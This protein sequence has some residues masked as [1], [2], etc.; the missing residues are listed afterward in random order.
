MFLGSLF[1]PSYR[2][3][4]SLHGPALPLGHAG[5]GKA[6][7]PTFPQRLPNSQNLRSAVGEGHN[8]D[9]IAHLGIPDGPCTLGGDFPPDNL[10]RILPD[11]ILFYGHPE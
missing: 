1:F 7:L 10:G 4:D 9:I 5:R 2:G 8:L 3:C 11:V 6:R